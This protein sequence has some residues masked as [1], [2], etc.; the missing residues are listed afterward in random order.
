M[1]SWRR[2]SPDLGRGRASAS[3]RVGRGSC[4]GGQPARRPRKA[5]IQADSRGE[6]EAAAQAEAAAKAQ[7]DAAAKAERE[8]AAKAGCRCS[9]GRQGDRIRQP[10]TPAGAPAGHPD[11]AGDLRSPCGHGSKPVAT[12]P[13]SGGGYSTTAYRQARLG[14]NANAIYSAVRTRFGITN[15][16]GYRAGDWG[17]HGAGNAVDVM[18]KSFA[19]G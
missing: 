9:P 10:G 15:I 18:T 12:T 2:L 6:A 17:D 7:A 16:G 3:G 5:A 1:L 14:T 13:A 11:H 4:G 8:A 19:E